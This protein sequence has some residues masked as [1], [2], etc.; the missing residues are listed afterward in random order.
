[1]TVTAHL[2]EGDVQRVA[3]EPKLLSA[4]MQAPK[5]REVSTR[6]DLCQRHFGGTLSNL[7]GKAVDFPQ[8]YHEKLPFAAVSS[9]PFSFSIA[10]LAFAFRP[11][12]RADVVVVRFV[13]PLFHVAEAYSD[14]LVR[15]RECGVGN[16]RKE[17]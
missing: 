5:G 4:W 14:G 12:D 3:S 7:G 15:A 10:F 8:N 17:P 11:T 6:S 16:C 9:L 13:V 2:G 1:M